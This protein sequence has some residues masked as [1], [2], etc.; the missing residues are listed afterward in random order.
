M[1]HAHR[2]MHAAFTRSKDYGISMLV[3]AKLARLSGVD[4][5]HTGTIVGK[6]EGAKDEVIKI[7]EDVADTLDLPVSKL[8]PT[9]RFDKD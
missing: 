5:L 7:W 2:A 1:I 3:V 6:M 9:D 4:S 8:R